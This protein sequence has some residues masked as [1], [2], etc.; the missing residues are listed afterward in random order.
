MATR[1]QFLLPCRSEEWLARWQSNAAAHRISTSKSLA[2]GCFI[3]LISCASHFIPYSR[4]TPHGYIK[5][6]Q[7][8]YINQ[9]SSQEFKTCSV[10]LWGDEMPDPHNIIELILLWRC[11]GRGRLLWNTNSWGASCLRNQHHPCCANLYLVSIG[12]RSVPHKMPKLINN[13]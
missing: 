9:G 1:C 6:I 10:Q 11:L 12:W 3:Q 8:R 2:A 5:T 13:N 7:A 4:G